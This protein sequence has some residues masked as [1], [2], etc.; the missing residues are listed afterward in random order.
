MSYGNATKVGAKRML[1][2]YRISWC[3]PTIWDSVGLDKLHKITNNP[4][5]PGGL[6]DPKGPLLN[7]RGCIRHF[8]QL[9]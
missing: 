9:H 3:D 1:K 2:Y 5:L 6:Q 8:V 4:G 7:D